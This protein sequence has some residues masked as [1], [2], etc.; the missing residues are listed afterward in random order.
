MLDELPALASQCNACVSL[1]FYMLDRLN[2]GVAATKLP[3]HRSM[4]T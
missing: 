4:S 1:T 3:E 2:I